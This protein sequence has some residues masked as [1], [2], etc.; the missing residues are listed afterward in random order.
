MLILI[1]TRPDQDEIFLLKTGKTFYQSLIS[2]KKQRLFELYLRTVIM[3]VHTG[4]LRW[5]K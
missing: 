1:M 3:V 4:W 2:L 5:L